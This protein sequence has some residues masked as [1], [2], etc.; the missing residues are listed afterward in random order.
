MTEKE[1]PKQD[2]ATQTE[3][4][5]DDIFKMEKKAKELKD[6]DKLRDKQK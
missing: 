3:L 6:K 1:K 2:E 4:S 5:K